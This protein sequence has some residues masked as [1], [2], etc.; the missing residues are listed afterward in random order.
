MQYIH[1]SQTRRAAGNPLTVAGCLLLGLLMGLALSPATRAAS[2]GSAASPP[3]A[4]EQAQRLSPPLPGCNSGNLLRWNPAHQRFHC[5]AAANCP[6]GHLL[7]VSNG[8][9]NCKAPARKQ[10]PPSPPKLPTALLGLGA[11]FVNKAPVPKQDDTCSRRPSGSTTR[12]ATGS[13]GGQHA[14]VT[15]K[16]YCRTPAGPGRITW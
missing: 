11:L 10:K 2:P 16:L 7:R 12:T 9:L 13:L 1:H 15:K 5:V 14:R 6:D 4:G 3:F 8:A